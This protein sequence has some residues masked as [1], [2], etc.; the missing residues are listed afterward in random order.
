LGDTG[1]DIDDRLGEH[2]G[3][4][5][6]ADVVDFGDVI[7]SD[8]E[9]AVAP[10]LVELLPAGVVLEEN[11][12]PSLGRSLGNVRGGLGHP[13]YLIDGAWGLPLVQFEIIEFVFTY[14]G[15]AFV[16]EVTAVA[17]AKFFEVSGGDA[18][19]SD[20]GEGIDEGVV[21][22]AIAVPGAV[23]PTTTEVSVAGVL[24]ADH[25]VAEVPLPPAT[26]R[27]G[28]FGHVWRFVH[29][30]HLVGYAGSVCRV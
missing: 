4:G 5:G 12:L 29:V 10:F 30:A 1:H 8:I 14:F 3:N 23:W 19:G 22:W 18:L 7:A 11:D 21:A 25:A 28:K 24:V 17:E 15:V 9:Y 2:A 6:T 26:F 13:G 16:D 20:F 27:F